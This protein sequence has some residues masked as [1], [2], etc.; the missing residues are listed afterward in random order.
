MRT[1][2]L[3]AKR[4][5]KLLKKQK[6][7]NMLELKKALGTNSSM[8]IFR[9]LKELDYISSCSDS[10]KYYSLLQIAQFDIR[11]L[12]LYKSV[13]FSTYGTLGETLRTLIEESEKGYS[14]VELETLLKVKPNEALLYLIKKKRIYREKVFGIYIYFSNISSVSK[15]QK[16][17]RKDSGETLGFDQMKPDILMNELKAAIIIFFSILNE[18]QRRLYAGLESLKIGRGGDKIISDLLGIN[19]KTV[20]KGKKELL[21]DTIKIDTIRD[22]G[23]GRKKTQKKNPRGDSKD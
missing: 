11:G 14:C 19:I 13:L 23:G 21:D 8:T 4:L 2:S 3:P 18:K 20:N 17:L 15:R 10:G 9:K 1:I 6:I 22:S 16:L 5:F 7:A 12:W